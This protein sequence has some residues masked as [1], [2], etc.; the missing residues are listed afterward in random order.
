MSTP[1]RW[2]PDTA[3]HPRR[4]P[5]AASPK[6]VSFRA[7]AEEHAALTAAAK[8]AGVALSDYVR[9]RVLR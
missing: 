5:D 8:A 2:T 1:H 4:L 3:P 7:T 9:G 6:I